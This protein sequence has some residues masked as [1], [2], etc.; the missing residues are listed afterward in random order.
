MLCVRLKSWGL[1]GVLTGPF[2]TGEIA[3]LAAQAR[4]S[5]TAGQV[6]YLPPCWEPFALLAEHA[7]SL[8]LLCM[9][10]RVACVISV[11]QCYCQRA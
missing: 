5:A 7:G 4:I 2:S 9:H 1:W 6:S 10:R 11:R 8:T 3:Q